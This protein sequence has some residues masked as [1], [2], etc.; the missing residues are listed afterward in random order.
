MGRRR[1]SPSVSLSSLF[2]SLS[3]PSTRVCSLNRVC[4]RGDMHARA[5]PVLRHRPALYM[6]DRP[7]R[8]RW[9]R[10]RHECEHRVRCVLAVQALARA[11]REHVCACDAPARTN[12]QALPSSDTRTGRP[13]SFRALAFGYRARVLPCLRNAFQMPLAS[14]RTVPRRAAFGAQHE[15]AGKHSQK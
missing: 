2:C 11:L 3:L 12:V 13:A 14:Q 7:P 9:H 8:C 4:W 1:L 10:R 6:L 5:M 15:H